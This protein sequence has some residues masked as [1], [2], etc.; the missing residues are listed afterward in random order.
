M[1]SRC[2]PQS[3]PPF[4]LSGMCWHHKLV[5]LRDPPWGDGAGSAGWWRPPACSPRSTR[6]VAC[7][8]LS[9]AGIATAEA[10]SARWRK[11]KALFDRRSSMSQAAGSAPRTGCTPGRGIEPRRS[12]RLVQPLRPPSSWLL[13]PS[14]RRPGPWRAALPLMLGGVAGTVDVPRRDLPLIAS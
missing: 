5:F 13:P 9:P 4:F 6:E 3:L 12:R 2:K 14:L 11:R 8:G 10:R 7:P 1:R